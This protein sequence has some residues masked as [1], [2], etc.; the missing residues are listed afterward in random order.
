MSV[1]SAP[2]DLSYD[3]ENLVEGVPTARSEIG[4]KGSFPA[5][6]KNLPIREKS[7]L[8]TQGAKT[9]KARLEV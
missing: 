4:L 7:S 2:E 5:R 6:R 3:K 8:R 1:V 9:E